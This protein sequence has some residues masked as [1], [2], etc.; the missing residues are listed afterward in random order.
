MANEHNLSQSM[1][2]RFHSTFNLQSIQKNPIF[3]L[4]RQYRM[5]EAICSWP[6][7]YFY[8]NR[9]ITETSSINQSN[10]PLLPYNVISLDYHQSRYGDD[11]SISNSNEA[12]FVVSLVKIISEKV[13]RDY[14]IGIITPYSGQMTELSN[15]LRL[16]FIYWYLMF[17]IIHSVPIYLF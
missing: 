11:P 2:S 4:R 1:F 3:C 12:D 16:A 13:N 6:N 17:T 9:L 8:D 7:G 10:F 5:P 15:K 14:S